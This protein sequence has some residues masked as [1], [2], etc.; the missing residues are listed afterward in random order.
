MKAAV[1]KKWGN[2]EVVDIEIPEPGP[3]ECL[4]KVEYAGVCGSDV[5]IYE[6]THPTAEAP[7]IL[8]H[9]IL[10]EVAQINGESSNG[11]KIGDKVTVEPLISC[12]VCEACRNGHFHVCRELRLLGVHED[13]GFAEYV[14]VDINKV[15][16]V[17]SIP[18]KIAVLT[19]PLAVGLHVVRRS[20]LKAGQKVLII[21]GGPIG[22]CIA[23]M[24]KMAGA[25]KVVVM[26]GNKKRIELLNDLGLI[27]IDAFADGAS[28]EA[29]A[30]TNQEGFDTVYEVTGSESGIR[31]AISNC[32]IRGC[33]VHVGFPGKN[34]EYNHLP[35]IFKELTVMGS[36]V[37]SMDDFVDTIN[38]IKVIVERNIFDL[39]KMISDVFSLNEIQKAFDMMLERTNLSKIVIKI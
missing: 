17:P 7:V 35:I 33:V 23:V 34:Y 37:Y 32:K 12:G 4:I 28:D 27:A 38:L 30:Y 14:K 1:L 26:E 13:G 29:M 2:I 3:G 9:E 21:G 10:G 24:A 36:R 31:T 11:L 39:G 20:E 25:S 22:I 6:G 5:H 15:V 18:D 16:K 19:E 8:C